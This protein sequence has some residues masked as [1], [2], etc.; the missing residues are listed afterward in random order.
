MAVLANLLAAL[1]QISEVKSADATAESLAAAINQAVGIAIAALR[2][3]EEEREA[4]Y[5][6]TAEIERARDMYGSDDIEVND[7]ALASHTDNGM[8]VAGWLWLANP[9][10]ADGDDDDGVETEPEFDVAN[11]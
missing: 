10:S 7:T 6:N 3:H 8:W 1:T 5:S 2:I 4:N 9:E 11:S